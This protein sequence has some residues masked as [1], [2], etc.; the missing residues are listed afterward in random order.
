M[1]K[2]FTILAMAVAMFAMTSCKETLG[3][4]YN[5]AIEGNATG[6]VVVTFPNGDF[7][8]NGEAGLAFHYS[9][10]TEAK[11]AT[12]GTLL[13]AALESDSK[14]VRELATTVNE[15]FSV[16]FKDTQAGGTYHV[17]V[18]GYAKEPTTG[19]VVLIDKTFDYPEKTAE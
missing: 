2:I 18:T 15:G 14:D 7:E 5:V 4:V 3:V 17:H 16:R 12:D 13:G 10:D 1:K 6:D 11:E 9:N 8:L 19:V